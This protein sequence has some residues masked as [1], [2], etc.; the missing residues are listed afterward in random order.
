MTSTLQTHCTDTTYCTPLLERTNS[1]EGRRFKGFLTAMVVLFSSGD[2]FDTPIF[3][4]DHGDLP[5]TYLNFCPFC[6]FDFAPR[7]AA[8]AQAKKASREKHEASGK[9]DF[10]Q[11]PTKTKRSKRAGGSAV[12]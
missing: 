2:M 5:P 8:F 12:A 10:I 1:Q 4:G 11:A 3:Y 6:G 7:L 9:R